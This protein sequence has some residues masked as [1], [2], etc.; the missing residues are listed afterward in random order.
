M[1]VESQMFQGLWMTQI[2]YDLIVIITHFLAECKWY[3]T[4]N[5]YWTDRSDIGNPNYL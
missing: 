1:V 5:P 4:I 3:K 2:K